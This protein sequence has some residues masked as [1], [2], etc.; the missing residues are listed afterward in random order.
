M[1]AV[2]AHEVEL[3]R[4]AIATLGAIDGLVIHGPASAEARS[5][6]VSFTLGDIHP[7]DLSTMLDVDHVCV[8]AGHHCA[9]PLMRALKVPATV[10]AS[11][12]VYNTTADIDALAASLRKAQ[13]RFG[14]HAD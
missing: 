11:F 2:R 6:V 10:R 9:Q 14:A 8:R 4:H 3:S 12:Y 1:D 7:H 13:E 5:G